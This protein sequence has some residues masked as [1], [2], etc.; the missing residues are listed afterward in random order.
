MKTTDGGKGFAND[1][2]AIAA[3]ALFLM[4]FGF[5]WYGILFRELQMEAHGYTPA[6]YDGNS[7]LWYI[8]GGLISVF[9]AWGLATFAARRGPGVGAAIRAGTTAFAGFG[10]P[11]VA[12]PFV[13]SPN[14]ALGLFLVGAAHLL[15]GWPVAAGGMAWIA[16]RNRPR[17]PAR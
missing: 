17:R 11:L 4:V 6:D 14:H 2:W 10:L 8:G 1:A 7:P 12:Y 9:I 16:S 15:I 3:G 5:V 13:Y